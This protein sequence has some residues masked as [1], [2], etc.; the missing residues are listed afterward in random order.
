MDRREHDRNTP[1]KPVM[2][3]L[4]L[5]VSGIYPLIGPL[6]D[7][8]QSG[9]SFTYLPLQQDIDIPMQGECEVVIKCGF[10]SFSDPYP[11]RVIYDKAVSPRGF[12]LMVPARRCGIQFLTPL[13]NFDIE[14][15]CSD[16]GA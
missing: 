2:V 9:L 13:S 6:V 1:Q 12:S 5:P 8:S 3:I 10:R 14:S 4:T 7:I 11:C 16:T 15:F